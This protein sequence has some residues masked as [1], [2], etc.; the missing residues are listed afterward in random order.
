MGQ[1]VDL[2][3]HRRR[4]LRGLPRGQAL[5]PRPPDDDPNPAEPPAAEPAGDTPP[6]PPEPAE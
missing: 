1:L 4:K 5:A 2:E 6:Q 3:Q